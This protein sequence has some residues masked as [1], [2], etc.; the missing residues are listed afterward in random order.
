MIWMEWDE[1]VNNSYKE[2]GSSAL[3]NVER[4]GQVYV[5]TSF[6]FTILHL[7]VPLCLKDRA[8][9]LCDVYSCN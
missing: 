5:T 3:N 6:I 9:L 7:F 4:R 1:R 8:L 2:T